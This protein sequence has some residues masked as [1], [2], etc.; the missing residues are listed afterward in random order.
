MSKGLTMD[1]LVSVAMT[2][3]FVG[4]AIAVGLWTNLEISQEG[5]GLTTNT[6]ESVTMDAV[7]AGND[8]T[9]WVSLGNQWVRSVSNV[10]ND[11]VN[12]VEI[13]AANYS[14]RETPTGTQFRCCLDSDILN[15][16]TKWVT[17]VSHDSEIY[18]YKNATQGIS[19]LST[20]LPVIA[21]VL[22][23][24]VIIGMLGTWF[25]GRKGM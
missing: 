12:S 2:L 7:G 4:V 21:V 3:I 16:S 5:T 9:T 13:L 6:N 20:W 8:N 11:S 25:V 24:A 14:T 22:A 23:A 17:Y 18:V 15:G 1:N 19:N 10:Y